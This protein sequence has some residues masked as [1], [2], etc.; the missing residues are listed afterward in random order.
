MVIQRRLPGYLHRVAL[1][2]RNRCLHRGRGRI[3]GRRIVAEQLDLGFH[4]PIA[5]GHRIGASNQVVQITVCVEIKPR[6]GAAR[7]NGRLG[8][9]QLDCQ[10]GQCSATIVRID[11]RS[12][13]NFAV[14]DI[15]A[16]GQ[17]VDVTVGIKVRPTGCMDIQPWDIWSGKS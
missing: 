8:R 1:Y 4:Q 11:E 15:T 5:V 9:W 14:A 12:A 17:Q 3:G 7:S 13:K 10:R 16:G 2:L 6:K